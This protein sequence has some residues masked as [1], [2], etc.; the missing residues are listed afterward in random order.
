MTVETFS[1][2][3]FWLSHLSTWVFFNYLINPVYDLVILALTQMFF[4]FYCLVSV[5][6]V[7]F[8]IQA[9]FCIDF[10]KLIKQQPLVLSI[11]LNIIR[12]LSII[13]IKHNLWNW[14]M[15]LIWFNAL[16]LSTKSKWIILLPF[17]L[18]IINLNLSNIFISWK[19]N[20]LVK[21]WIALVTYDEVLHLVFAR[22]GVRTTLILGVWI[23]RFICW[24]KCKFYLWNSKL[25]I[26]IQWFFLSI[27]TI[28]I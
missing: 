25:L 16:L 13:M 1:G 15:V 21:Y 3:I 26:N 23:H 27:Y 2:S 4:Y 9:Y 10:R 28:R 5:E 12:T 7:G 24:A 8:S 6:K 11:K 14:I 19:I 20:M 18:Y 22:T 17:N